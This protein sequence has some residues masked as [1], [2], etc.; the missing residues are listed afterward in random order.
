MARAKWPAPAIAQPPPTP[1]VDCMGQRLGGLKADLSRSGQ[2]LARLPQRL[3][4]T[5]RSVNWR[6]LLAPARLVDY[7]G[8]SLGIA[9]TVIL[10]VHCPALGVSG[11]YALIAASIGLHLGGHVAGL[12]RPA[13]S[14]AETLFRRALLGA[15]VSSLAYCLLAVLIGV[16]NP[17]GLGLFVGGHALLALAFLALLFKNR[18]GG[19]GPCLVQTARDAW[20]LTMHADAAPEQCGGGTAANPPLT[21]PSH[22]RADSSSGTQM[23][24]KRCRP[25]KIG[26]CL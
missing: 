15:S 24:P 18:H 12:L 3:I 20:R 6:A 22:R 14:G 1:A 13:A 19:I 9:G 21:T 23:P 25:K 5:G 10:A 4:T 16:G 11:G 2:T 26:V 8:L 7:A 17:V